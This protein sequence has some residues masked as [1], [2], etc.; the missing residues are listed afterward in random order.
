MAGRG[1]AARVGSGVVAIDVG[2]GEQGIAAGSAGDCGRALVGQLG[3]G[4]RGD[5]GLQIVGVADV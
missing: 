1:V 5:A 4:D 3:E 2:E